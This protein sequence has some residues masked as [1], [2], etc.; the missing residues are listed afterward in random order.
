[1]K[2][3]L[4]VHV[5]ISALKRSKIYIHHHST[6]LI[7][8]SCV[9]CF[10]VLKSNCRIRICCVDRFHLRRIEII[11]ELIRKI[12]KKL[13]ATEGGSAFASSFI[14]PQWST[15]YKL[16][17]KTFIGLYYFVIVQF[18]INYSSSKRITIHKRFFP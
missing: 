7:P 6:Q 5:R 1:M 8:C 13:S 14:A 4:R 10:S 2:Q 11:K 18:R 17:Y 9:P 16:C 12:W 3:I 15:F